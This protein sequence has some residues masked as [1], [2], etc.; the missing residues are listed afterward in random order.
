MTLAQVAVPVCWLLF[1]LYWAL[2]ARSVK[3]AAERASG[4]KRYWHYIFLV[5]A[6]VLLQ[7]IPLYPLDLTLIPRSIETAILISACAVG[8]LVIAIVARRT[9]ADNWS[10]E[11]TFKREHELITHG[12][13]HYMRHP[14][15]TG[16]L[17]MFIATVLL[18]GTVGAV[19]GFLLIAVGLWFKLRQ[20]EALM[21]RHFPREYPPYKR[22]VK[23]LI[24][25]IF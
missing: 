13:Y 16:V 18:V 9:L 10:S 23:A 24:P 2:G 3:P 1:A 22:Q 12:I 11:V 20:E 8:G 5:L 17:L 25:L 14:I 6:A 15:Y 7:H 21:E 4:W 19:I